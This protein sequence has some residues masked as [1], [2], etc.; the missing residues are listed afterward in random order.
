MLCKNIKNFWESFIFI[1]QKQITLIYIAW[2]IISKYMEML[3]KSIHHE[4]V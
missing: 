4:P 1:R 2:K 3:Y